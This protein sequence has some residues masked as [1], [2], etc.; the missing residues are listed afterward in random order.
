MGANPPP[1]PAATDTAGRRVEPP[2]A[3]PPDPDALLADAETAYR[4]LASLRAAFR[5]TVE[6]PLL[7]RSSTGVG[8]WYQEG[9]DRFR[10]DF[11][12]PPED[13][14]VADGTYLW[15][16]QPSV[17]PHQVIRSDLA[18]GA[19]TAG[20]ADLLGRILSEART[21]YDATDRGAETV[22]GVETRVVELA[23]RGP[24]DYRQVTLWIAEADR[25][26][27]RFR[28]EQENG[29][30]RTVTLSRLEP[31]VPLDDSLFAFTPPPGVDVFER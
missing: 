17:Q 8:I 14:F 19:A 26:V 7:D 1:T 10:M 5:Q 6:V 28:I 30:L 9:P 27:R 16:Y 24:S 2:P 4:R 18:G 23:P 31:G 22:D 12:D 29:T 13:V 21:G 3:A 25:L 11:T 15:L 20:T